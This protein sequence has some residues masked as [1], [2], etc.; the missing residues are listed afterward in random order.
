[1]SDDRRDAE[2][3]DDEL[4]ELL[5]AQFE[6]PPFAQEAVRDR[7]RTSMDAVD[8]GGAFVGP[9][10]PDHAHGPASG[11]PL[12]AS[13]SAAAAAVLIFVG[14]AEYGR[15]TAGA[16]VA[17]TP[18]AGGPPSTQWTARTDMA[19]S[20]S[21]PI[22]IQEAGSRYIS[23]LA[24]LT[25]RRASLSEGDRVIAEDVAWSSL[26]GAAT[27]L[28]RLSENSEALAEVILLL[29]RERAGPIRSG[30]ISF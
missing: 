4:R 25:A 11:A 5:Q 12:L 22:S 14:G 26:R 20:A 21:L 29:E 17:E 30:G 15:R 19:A 28:A 1:M 16:T 10:R 6:A 2:L 13:L 7:I 24:Q 18:G 3:A 8:A 9:V 27:E 23:R